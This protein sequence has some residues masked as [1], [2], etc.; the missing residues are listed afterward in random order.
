MPKLLPI[1]IRGLKIFW[2]YIYYFIFHFGNFLAQIALF[3]M[4]V[5]CDMSVHFFLPRLYL[6]TYQHICTHGPPIT[7]SQ[8]FSSHSIKVVPFT[9]NSTLHIC[10]VGKK[11]FLTIYLHT[12]YLPTC[13]KIFI[14]LLWSKLPIVD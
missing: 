12:T 7:I 4:V 6:P 11:M 14:C 9:Y 5:Y 2:N 1:Y 8:V 10:F 13:M 3:S